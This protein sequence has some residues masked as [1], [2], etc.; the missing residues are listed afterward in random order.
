MNRKFALLFASLALL[1]GV[2]A[3]GASTSGVPEEVAAPQAEAEVS[4]AQVQLPTEPPPTEPPEPTATPVPTETPEP[5]P[6]P[7]PIILSGS[8]DSILDVDKPG[9]PMLVSIKGNSC[10]RYFVVTSLDENNETL[11]LLV[12]TTDPYEGSG[13]LDFSDFQLTVRLQVE[14]NCEWE[15][16]ILPLSAAR[17]L[18]IP[19]SISG[20]GD[21]LFLLDGGTPDLVHVVGNS[22][23]RYFG[24][25]S[26]SDFSDLVVNTTDPYDGTGILS[27]NTVAI[28]VEAVGEWTIEISEK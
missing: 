4:E 18:T 7:D 1:V 13:P 9:S 16:S 27:V 20:T 23:G 21:E 5:T 6:E 10:S 14:S 28:E 26:Y 2:S 11:D 17:T 25:F 15:I 12:N 19:G 3:C 22:A 24:V 8:G